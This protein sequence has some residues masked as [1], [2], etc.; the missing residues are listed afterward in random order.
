VLQPAQSGHHHIAGD[1]AV[2]ARV[3]RVVGSD[4]EAAPGA[5]LLE[6]LSARS[7][8]RASP[9]HPAPAEGLKVACYYGCLLTRHPRSPTSTTPRTTLMDR[10]LET[11]APRRLNGRTRRNAAGEFS[12]TDAS[13]VLELSNQILAMAKAAGPTA[14]PPPARCAN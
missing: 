10:L 3:A 14:S 13:I 6:I 11:P 8:S 2:R 4:Y 5:H 7:A 1:A 9:K 12:I